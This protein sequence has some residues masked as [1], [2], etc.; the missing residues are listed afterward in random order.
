[1]SKGNGRCFACGRETAQKVHRFCPKCHGMRR[2][3]G[4]RARPIK[5]CF[6]RREKA[7]GI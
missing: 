1:M 6:A 7:E 2:T 5:E 3:D 4:A